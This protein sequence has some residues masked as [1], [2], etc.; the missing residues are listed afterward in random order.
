M[1]NHPT[2]LTE[3]QFQALRSIHAEIT[4]LSDLCE[5]PEL[6]AVAVLLTGIETRLGAILEAIREGRP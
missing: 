2:T 3:G 4:A 5:P 1:T 6:A